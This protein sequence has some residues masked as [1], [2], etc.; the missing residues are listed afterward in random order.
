MLNGVKFS[1]KMYTGFTV[2]LFLL[3]V[4]AFTGYSGMQA[5]ETSFVNY[6][7][8]ARDTNLMGRLQAN[9]LLTRMGVK[10]FLMTS[11]EQHLNNY[12]TR[13]ELMLQFLEDAK[14]DIQ[15]P[16]RAKQVTFITDYVDDYE[17][18]FTQVVDLMRERHEIVKTQLD[19]HGLKMHQ[20]L[21]N[22]MQSA[23]ED[24]DV[25]AAYY[26]GRVLEH[27]L[28]GRLNMAKYLD[29]NDMATMGIA[30][31]EL[32][33][34]IQEPLNIL[35][36]E[37]Q[38]SVRRGLL[39]EFIESRTIYVENLERLEV[40]ITERNRQIK[41]VLDT[42]G[43]QISE[44]A[45]QIKLSVK[46]EQDTLGPALQSSIQQAVQT[47]LIIS[48]SALLLGMVIAF[49]ITRSLTGPLK[50]SV[51]IAEQLAQGN[52][53]TTIEVKG[54]DEINQLLAA[55]KVMVGKL[56]EIVSNVQTGADY[57]ASGSHQLSSTAQQISRGTTEQA[58]SIEQTSSTMEEMSATTNNNAENASQTEQ[59]ARQA[60]NDAQTSGQAVGDMVRAMQEIA[61]KISI[62]EEI[63]RQ[64][65]LLALNAAIEAARAGEHGKGFA[66]VA[67]E[68]RKLAERTQVAAGDISQVS[69]SSVE[70]A[71]RAGEMLA[72]LVPDIERTSE[73]VR[74]ISDACREQSLGTEQINR[75]I[76][77]L[78]QVIQQNASSS[79]EMA[80]TSEELSLQAAQLQDAIS[81]FKLEQ[82]PEGL[83]SAE[84]RQ[85]TLLPAPHNQ[86]R[87]VQQTTLKE[88]QPAA[89]KDKGIVLD[90]GQDKLALNKEFEP[91][92]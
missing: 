70:V 43:P 25:I 50:Q 7:E 61:E 55:M 75:A 37:I 68:V 15:K 22:I 89:K 59:I 29:T 54:K 46:E 5:T 88:K 2:V 6:R 4:V 42:I 74:E 44:V 41:E 66:V 33:I 49:L 9:M 52:M 63:S 64:T 23:F 24:Q 35:L 69:N 48:M 71:E 13:H 36:R 92:F 40:V 45:E 57:V 20:A 17:N 19:P 72:K 87:I 16:E 90:L 91:Y 83:K 28:L 27:L 79:E 56:R 82:T 76:Q 67:S 31:Q 32:G 34:E 62:V 3:F 18:S 65:N 11:D 78:D 1:T 84:E 12:K 26:A 47:I 80:S 21:S 39:N 60:A 8:L 77:Q 81:Y 86:K 10:D 73:L 30:K 85:S 53:Q 38:N 51:K 14:L 58:S